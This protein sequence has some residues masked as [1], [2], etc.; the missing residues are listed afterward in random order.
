MIKKLQHQVVQTY[1]VVAEL[2]PDEPSSS[3]GAGGYDLLAVT[4]AAPATTKGGSSTGKK[5]K[6]KKKSDGTKQAVSE[7]K[8]QEQPVK[9]ED[10]NVSLTLKEQEFLTETIPNL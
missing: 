3:I 7:K 8:K 5:K 9:S 4:A 1:K 2:S 10:D 6:S